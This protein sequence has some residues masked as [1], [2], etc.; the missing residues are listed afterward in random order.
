MVE[1]TKKQKP[2]KETKDDKI[3]ELTDSLQRLQA[4]FENYKKQC[5]K[6]G[7]LF[8]ERVVAH[9]I[10]QLLPT[11]DHFQLALEHKGNDEEFIKGVELIYSELYSLLENHGVRPIEALGKKFDPY[12]HEV[13]LQEESDKEDMILEEMQRGY[14]LNDKVLRLSKVKIGKKK[15]GR[16]KGRVDKEKDN[17]KKNT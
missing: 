12:K 14:M 10:E 17:T 16:S 4:D 11:V 5:D 15:D 7:N 8:K 9:L 2:K 1:K 6:E 13:L 3:A